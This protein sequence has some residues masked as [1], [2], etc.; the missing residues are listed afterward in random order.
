MDWAWV[1]KVKI[2]YQMAERSLPAVRTRSLASKNDG[3]VQAGTYGG[4]A[5]GQGAW[6]LI[7]DAMM[8][9]VS[10]DCV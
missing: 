8:A 3:I 9:A 5:A 10:S 7:K 6:E 2:T 1:I 4:V